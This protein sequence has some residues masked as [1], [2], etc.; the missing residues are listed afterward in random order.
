MTI[1]NQRK[2]SHFLLW[3][4]LWKGGD[5]IGMVHTQHSV[6]KLPAVKG[7]A[8]SRVN[9][10]TSYLTNYIT[11]TDE[12]LALIMLENN[13][14]R[15]MDECRGIDIEDVTEKPKYTYKILGG[16]SRKYNG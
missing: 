8:D 3:K 1:T 13:W 9:C 15:W 12:G 14:E 10:R 6:S 7:K 16:G 2:M 4:T 11:P 5:R